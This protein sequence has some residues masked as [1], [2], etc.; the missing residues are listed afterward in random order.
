MAIEYA[1]SPV[2]QPGTH[3]RTGVAG[4][5]GGDQPGERLG[6]QRLECRC[7]AEE[8]GDADEQLAEEGLD[9]E[10]VALEERDVVLHALDP[11]D[12]H[13]A[14]HA[15]PQRVGLVVREVVAA[16]LAQQ[17]QHLGQLVGAPV[18]AAARA[19]AAGVRRR[20]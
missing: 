14:L 8:V 7:V 10:R 5:V 19:V 2:E 1:S 15:P 3:T 6:G 9:L 18:A 11:G 13:A 20:G 12:G 17:V 16:A 4:G